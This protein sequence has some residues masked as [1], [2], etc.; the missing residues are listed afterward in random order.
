[1]NDCL[2]PNAAHDPASS[3]VSFDQTARTAECVG[4]ASAPR[5]GGA[6]AALGGEID[7]A[8]TVS[9]FVHELMRWRAHLDHI[10]KLERAL[11]RPTTQASPLGRL[12]QQA[13]L[14]ILGSG[15]K[16]SKGVWIGEGP[17]DA[18]IDAAEAAETI[19]LV[20][21]RDQA[22]RARLDAM[23]EDLAIVAAWIRDETKG[24][25]P[26][27]QRADDPPGYVLTFDDGADG[28][29]RR[30]E[31]RITGLTLAEVV[32]LSTAEPKQRARWEAKMR[33]GDGAMARAGMQEA[34]AEL[35]LACAL[36]WFQPST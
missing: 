23:P 10:D 32:G 26:P 17:V 36:A 8:R 29:R 16:G 2:S 20:D 15:C 11:A 31:R 24:D 14:G 7:A 34:G 35:L 12:E 13:G 21:G 9:H 3:S 33:V 30:V 27:R 19:E 28:K 4:G 1:M 6:C 18:L 22:W 25:S 5:P